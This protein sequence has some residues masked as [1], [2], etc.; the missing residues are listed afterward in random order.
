[1]RDWSIL[2]HALLHKETKFGAY[3]MKCLYGA[4]LFSL[5][6]L[7]DAAVTLQT[8][9]KKPYLAKPA[10]LTKSR[11]PIQLLQGSSEAP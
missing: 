1:M 2:L 7:A 4:T 8:D 6:V 10:H 9:E 11:C 3:P 5:L